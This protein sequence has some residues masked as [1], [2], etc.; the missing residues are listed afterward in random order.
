MTQRSTVRT[1]I[2]KNTFRKLEL[3]KQTHSKVRDIKHI[4]LKMQDYFLPNSIK[5]VTMQEIQLIFQMRSKVINLKLNMKSKYETLKCQ[6]CLL[7]NESQQHVYECEQIWSKRDIKNI[8][9]PMYEN[10]IWGNV[11][12]KIKV[13]RI[14]NKNMKILERTRLR[15]K[16]FSLEKTL[17]LTSF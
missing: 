17:V 14:F 12:Q 5:N 16:V 2:E 13:A 3:M 7:E 11:I 15:S 9:K 6:A 4:K 8:E 10:I 1:F